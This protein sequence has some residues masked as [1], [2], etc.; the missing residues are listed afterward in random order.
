MDFISSKSFFENPRCPPA[1]GPSTTIKS[2]V[3]FSFL[4]QILRTK[5]QALDDETIGAILTLEPLVRLGNFQI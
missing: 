4:S 3:V 2:A 1:L 5:L